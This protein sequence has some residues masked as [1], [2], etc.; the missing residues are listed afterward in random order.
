MDK[1]SSKVIYDFS[2]KAYVGVFAHKSMR[3]WSADCNDINK[4]KKIRVRVGWRDAAY[5]LYMKLIRVVSFIQLS[6]PAHSLIPI[7]GGGT[8]VLYLDGTCESLDYAIEMR[9]EKKDLTLP[10]FKPIID[11]ANMKI[12]NAAYFKTTPDTILL[13]YF[14]ESLEN[15]TKYLIYFKIDAEALRL[16]GPVN[17]LRLFRDEAQIQL[18]GSTVVDSSSFPQL[19][20]ICKCGA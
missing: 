6:K 13:T 18:C 3:C 17:R 11:V 15:H 4:I 9:K 8:I 14:V 12:L 1:L 5:L 10:Q 20:T 16:D 19:V 7:D 2:T